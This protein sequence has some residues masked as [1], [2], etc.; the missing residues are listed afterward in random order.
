MCDA[1]KAPNARH[2]A[3]KARGSLGEL[4]AGLGFK[5][6]FGP[7][8]VAALLVGGTGATGRGAQVVVFEAAMGPRIG[9]AIVAIQHGLNPRLVTSMVGIGIPLSLSTAALWSLLLAGMWRI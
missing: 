6:V 4:L 8:L 5:L 7:A 9:S 2:C 3:R 1:A